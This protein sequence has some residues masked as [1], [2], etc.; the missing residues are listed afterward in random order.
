[1]F[2]SPI[3]ADEYD[4]APDDF[5]AALARARKTAP[6]PDGLSAA[7][8]TAARPRAAATLAR[9]NEHLAAGHPPPRTL[10]DATLVCI[11]KSAQDPTRPR[12]ATALSATR[13]FG[14]KRVDV[15]IIAPLAARSLVH[16]ASRQLTAD[17]QGSLPGSTTLA[18]ILRI[19]MASRCATW[20]HAGHDPLLI[21]FDVAAAFPSVSR[22]TVA[23][24][25]D[26]HELQTSTRR[27]VRATHSQTRVCL[28]GA[29]DTGQPF[30][31]GAGVPQGCPLSA[32][33]FVLTA[34]PLLGMLRRTSPELEAHMA[35][36]HDR[37]S[38][39]LGT[40][41]QE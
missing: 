10:N 40:R 8:W 34:H 9:L 18:A 21:A 20:R 23:T 15:K 28:Q 32:V 3:T 41:P 39:M 13:P 35:Y 14:L 30:A 1:M 2:G 16:P 27:I 26:F 29:T 19:D 7:C 37:L 24:A 12:S 17:Q 25:H 11:P 33:L 6:R 5:S 36:A 22:E 4:A 31:P 38:S